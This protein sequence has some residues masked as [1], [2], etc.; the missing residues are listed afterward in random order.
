V[1]TS[2]FPERPPTTRLDEAGL[3]PL[4][5][6]LCLLQER[7]II[8]V[9][10]AKYKR[11][12]VG[13]YRNADLYQ[14]LAYTVALDLPGGM[15]IYAADEGVRVAEHVVIQAGKRLRVV[16]L[17]LLAPRT[18]LLQQVRTIAQDIRMSALSFT[19]RIR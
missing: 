10:D 12:P 17:D 7:K 19:G 6:D 14:L 4:K 15:L 16:A 13:A 2:R 9:G 1:D 5:P 3:I 11:L 18:N 8:W